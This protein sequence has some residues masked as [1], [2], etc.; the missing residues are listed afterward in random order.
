MAAKYTQDNRPMAVSTPLAKDAL[1]LERL[2]GTEAL[3]ELFRFDLDLLAQPGQ[4][5]PFDKLI[6]QPATVRLVPRGSQR[7]RFVNGILSRV[8]QGGV[9]RGP[10]GEATYTR[11][12]AVL[13]PAFWK[14]TR[15]VRS[16]AFQQKSIPDVLKE[17]LA[18]LATDFRLTGTYHP[19]DYVAQYNESD[20]A[21]ASR[22]M[23]EEGIFY[24]FKH[25]DGG[26]TMVLGDHVDAHD[27]V[28][29]EAGLLYDDIVGVGQNAPEDRVYAW[30][31]SQELRSGKV[32]LWD[33][34]F[35]LPPQNL[36]AAKATQP[37]VAV[38]GVAHQLAVGGNDQLELYTYPGRY[39]QRYDGIDP[40]GGDRP[41]D[42]A[43]I[44]EDNQRTAALRMQQEAA[45]AV[46]VE[47]ASSVRTLTA[48]HQF[49]LA[50]GGDRDGE[51]VVR[52]VEHTGDLR[53]A[54][55]SRESDGTEEYTN[56]FAV[57]PKGLPFR[58]PQATPKGRIDGV[59]AATVVG[60]AGE[61]IFTD[62]YGRVKVQ[63]RWDR[64]GTND[65][66]SSCWVRVGSIWAGKGWGAVHT[67]R[68]G[69]EVIVAFEEG[70]PDRPI[71][72]G[73]VYNAEQM[74]PYPLPDQKTRSGLKSRSTLRGT[75]DNF[76]E[77]RFEDKKDAEQIYFHAEKDFDQVVENNQTLKVGFEKKDKGDQATEIYND[78][79]LKVGVG[80][81]TGSQT[82]TVQKDRTV[83]LNT[84]ND[85]LQVKQGNRDV[86]ID[87]GNDA[88]TIKM[89]DQTTKLNLG[90]AL[91]DALQS[92]TL[93]VG[94]SK[95][96]V[97]QTGVKIDGMMIKINGT[98]MTDIKG[99]MTT[100]NGSALLKMGGGVTMIG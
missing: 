25:A 15:V 81:G 26:H 8:G 33:H 95:I 37:V 96:V 16:R 45:Q 9:S 54:Y 52:S 31:K 17:V 36:E 57:L 50:R 10:T 5:V 67:P 74:P 73:S 93:K 62:K 51:Y 80:S 59:Q 92:I 7:V 72:L 13:V 69:Q 19:R 63:F 46:A 66:G 4:E 3:S 77:L 55:H 22:L 98:A 47:G 34:S 94:A 42:V 28:P 83:T 27:P 61:E 65:P 44:S 88:L 11:Y 6:G 2:R 43:K 89:G 32:T 18:G 14:L 24:Y 78:Q 1:L 58:P 79:T 48:G 86:L 90:K 84:G 35:E 49:R 70:D 87:M 91:T 75:A 12:T 68:V 97:D 82:E 21:F 39:S 99:A 64:E 56:S 29:G 71:I 40:G 53:A 60:P 23:E 85:K 76:N 41:P 100:V 38:G 20:H 30:T